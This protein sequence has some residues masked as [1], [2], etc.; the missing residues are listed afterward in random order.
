MYY[1]ENMT[2]EL[3]GYSR[4]QC[5]LKGRH[6]SNSEALVDALDVYSDNQKE[7]DGWL[8]YLDQSMTDY[9]T[10]NSNNDDQDWKNIIKEER[11]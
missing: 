7:F 11:V 8:Q 2:N 4:A 5:K 9:R 10:I 6:R 1:K 3:H